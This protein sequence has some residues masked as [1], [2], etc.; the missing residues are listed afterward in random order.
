MRQREDHVEVRDRQ[1]ILCL[2]HEPLI[3]LVGLTLRAMS[4]STGVIG[5]G[6]KAASGTLV[7]MTAEGS[8]AAVADGAQY[9]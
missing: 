1:E 7:Q 9:F 5:D 4:V 8:R 6:L 2:L 3:T